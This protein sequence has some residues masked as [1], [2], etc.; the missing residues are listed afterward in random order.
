MVEP[1]QSLKVFV[2]STFKDL[3]K[4]RDKLHAAFEGVKERIAER[5]LSLIPYDLRWR[6]RKPGEPVVD[7]CLEAV[8]ECQYFVNILD[9]RYGWRPPDAGGGAANV[10]ALSI[11][12]METEEAVRRG[13]R[14]LF[15][16]R[17]ASRGTPPEAKQEGANRH[18]ESADD[19]R[20]WQ[21]AAPKTV[22]QLH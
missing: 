2:S 9:G 11:T 7:W 14:R 13:A 8:H 20:R 18:H 6:D 15:F 22:A 5:R 1:W 19:R 3:E 21:G 12:E 16:F 17:E 10:R 4:E